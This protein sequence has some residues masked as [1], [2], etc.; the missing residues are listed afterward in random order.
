MAELTGTK[1]PAH[2]PA[3]LIE[4]RPHAGLADLLSDLSRANGKPV[5]IKVDVSGMQSELQE[6]VRMREAA[7]N[8]RQVFATALESLS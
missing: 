5:R 6:L 7:N 3:T 1:A 2:A 8:M 4:C